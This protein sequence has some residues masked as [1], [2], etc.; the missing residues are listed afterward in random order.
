MDSSGQH[1]IEYLLGS[2]YLWE[3]VPAHKCA[4][5]TFITK[6]TKQGYRR[7]S[8]RF[9]PWSLVSVVS[10]ALSL[11]H[12]GLYHVALYHLALCHLTH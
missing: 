1:A 11:Y 5:K 4:H 7:K 2:Y 8:F 3:P 6:G 9:A 12:W 10:I